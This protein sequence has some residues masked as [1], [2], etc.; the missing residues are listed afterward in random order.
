MTGWW[1]R[2]AAAA[3]A[4]ALGSLFLYSLRRPDWW[5]TADQR[6]DALLRQGRDDEAARAYQ[7]PARQGTALYR[8]G[9]F[10]EAAAAFARD[11]TAEAAFNRGDALV[12]LGKY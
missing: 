4:L 1:L 10:K 2:V 7:G 12:M 6:G 11:P 3:V 9:Q 5:W 8:A